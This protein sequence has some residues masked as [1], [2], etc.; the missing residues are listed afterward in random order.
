[1]HSDLKGKFIPVIHQTLEGI[2]FMLK[3]KVLGAFA[4]VGLLS[5]CV[6]G[7]DIEQARVTEAPSSASDFNRALV[8]EYQELMVFEADQMYDWQSAKLYADK[9]LAAARDED[10]QPERLEDWSLPVDKIGELTFARSELISVLDKGARTKAP[11]DAARAQ[12]MFDCWVEQKEENHQPAHIA[13]CKS[14]FW[15]ALNA[16]RASL[17]EAKPMQPAAATVEPQRYVI[18]FDFDSATVREDGVAVLK[19]ALSDAQS[20]G[21]IAF[22]VTGHAD[23]A[24]SEEYNQAL[25][26]RRADAVRAALGAKGIMAQN[27]S[28]AARGESEPAVAT[29]DGV[30]EP[31]NRRVEVILQ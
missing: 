22:S 30:A 8:E 9:S 3:M 7:Y 11:A 10:V 31:K 27:V 16:A 4:A 13:R 28:V 1:M 2:K 24:G 15:E 26:L 29:P 21:M 18:Y 12:A 14:R 6:T 17:V 23:R 20:M 19:Q 25:S 5:G